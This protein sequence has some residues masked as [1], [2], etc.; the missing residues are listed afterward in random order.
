MIA[1]V[2]IG[3]AISG[4]ARRPP[5]AAAHRAPGLL[6]RCSA[7]SRST[8]SSAWFVAPG[9][10]WHVLPIMVFTTG[11]AI[12]TPTVTLLMLDLFPAMRGLVS[13]LQGFF[14]FALA[15]IVAGSIA[16][17]LAQSLQA[18][19]LGM[20]GFTMREP[21]AL[22]RLPAPHARL[23]TA[24]HAIVNQHVNK[25]CELRVSL[26]TC[27]ALTASS[28]L[29]AELPTIELRI[30]SHKLVAEIAA[31]PRY[32]HHR[33]DESLQPAARSRH[34]VRVRRAAAARVLD[35]QYLRAAVDRVHRRR[36]AHPQ[37]RG[38]GAANR[39]HPP[40]ARAPRCTR[41]R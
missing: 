32:A 8:W 37:H 41:S 3:A 22:A 11:S 17:L 4:R 35:A 9:V 25:S 23:G 24:T 33:P 13:S 12:I 6:D 7:E 10:P 15:A 14:H 28:A 21:R 2:M 26:A 40:V 36:R 38:H 19:A 39:G 20:A 16:P 29:A 1:G 34:A 31:T 18:L 5:V 27:L 30:G